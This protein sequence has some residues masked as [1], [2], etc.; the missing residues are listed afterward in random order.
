M[1]PGVSEAALNAQG[2]FDFCVLKSYFHKEGP[3]I[4]FGVQT[5]GK[6]TGKFSQDQNISIQLF[7]DLTFCHH[8]IRF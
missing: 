6:G 1:A 2:L 4:W 8:V 3:L 5:Q 7:C